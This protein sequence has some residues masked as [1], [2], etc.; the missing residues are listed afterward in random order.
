MIELYDMYDDLTEELKNYIDNLKNKTIK[1]T[2]VFVPEKIQKYDTPEAH[3]FYK[4]GTKIELHYRQ[5]EPDGYEFLNLCSLSYECVYL[6]NL[7][8]ECIIDKELLTEVTRITKN[9]IG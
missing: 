1:K 9:K 2:T 3:I 4:D 7:D 6:T 5:Q 8:D